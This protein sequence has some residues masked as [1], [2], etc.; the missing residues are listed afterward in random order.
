M[1]R[2]ASGSVSSEVIG[3]DKGFKELGL[4]ET[5]VQQ[6]LELIGGSKCAALKDKWNEL[7]VAELELFVKRSELMRNQ[8]QMIYDAIKSDH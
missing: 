1:K 5:I 8:A 2:C 6:G 3:F 7:H 4:S